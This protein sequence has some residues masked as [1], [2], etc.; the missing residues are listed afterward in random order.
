MRVAIVE[1]TAD[2]VRVVL[3]DWRHG[4]DAIILPPPPEPVASAERICDAVATMLGYLWDRIVGEGQS[5]EVTYARHVAMYLLAHD[6]QVSV[7][8]IGRMMGRDHSTVLAGIKR[9][10]GELATRPET[11]EDIERC[12]AALRGEK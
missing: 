7:V 5:R 8:M 6:G 3:A 11:R 1:G 4:I 12:R 9:I 10:E 2:E